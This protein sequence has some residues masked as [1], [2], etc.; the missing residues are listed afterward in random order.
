MQDL[1]NFPNLASGINVP[2][3]T[4]RSS[5]LEV[6]DLDLILRD[7]KIRWSGH[8]ER[9]S[10]TFRKACDIQVEDKRVLGGPSWQVRNWP[11]TTAVSGITWKGAHWCGWCPCTCMLIK[12]LIMIWWW[13]VHILSLAIDNSPSWNNGR[14]RMTIEIIS[15]S[16]ST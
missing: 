8:V 6:E 11:K 13:F 7:R 14:E 5:K 4:V 16:N 1:A 3:A 15:W 2:F 10:G 9:S 12:N